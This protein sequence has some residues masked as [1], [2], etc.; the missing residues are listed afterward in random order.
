ML[1]VFEIFIVGW[2]CCFFF[3][4]R[5][6]KIFFQ[7]SLSKV[8]FALLLKF[9]AIQKRNKK[10]NHDKWKAEWEFCRLDSLK[11]FFSS[12]I[13]TASGLQCKVINFDRFLD[14]NCTEAQ[15]ALFV[16]IFF[17]HAEEMGKNFLGLSAFFIIIHH[18]RCQTER[19]FFTFS[20]SIFSYFFIIWKYFS[21]PFS[22]QEFIY[23]KIK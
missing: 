23:L 14:Y 11:L 4:Q 1:N 17:I 3:Y 19:I 8:L 20:S 9:I 7:C 10:L 13:Q 16:Y 15:K 22:Q 18:R 21:P 12:S 5:E 6:R 2:L